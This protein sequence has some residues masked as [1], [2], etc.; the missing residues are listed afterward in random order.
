MESHALFGSYRA[1]SEKWE[2]ALSVDPQIC[3]GKDTEDV[4]CKCPDL[5]YS[6]RV[7]IRDGATFNSYIY[8][9]CCD[10]PITKP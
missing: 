8:C 10:L 1:H 2:R 9:G 4:N 6:T 7:R 3:P 5:V